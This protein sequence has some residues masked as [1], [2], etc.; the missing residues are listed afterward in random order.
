MVINDVY[1]VVVIKKHLLIREQLGKQPTSQEV[2]P[3]L[4]T[5]QPL[6]KTQRTSAGE[7]DFWFGPFVF[8][9][10]YH[11]VISYMDIEHHHFFIGTSSM[12]DFQYPCLFT[13]G[14]YINEFMNSKRIHTFH[15]LY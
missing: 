5:F 8:H 13:R 11:L 9:I 14:C 2:I 6:G 10:I 12:L 1:C 15:K 7:A 4:V 3:K